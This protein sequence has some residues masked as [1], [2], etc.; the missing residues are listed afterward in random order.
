LGS[1]SFTGDGRGGGEGKGM[2]ERGTGNAQGT[3]K[4]TKKRVWE[5]GGRNEVT[6]AWRAG[7]GPPTDRKKAQKFRGESWGGEGRK[8]EL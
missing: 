7:R 3:S 6:R 8:K 2:G 1:G 5:E 4:R